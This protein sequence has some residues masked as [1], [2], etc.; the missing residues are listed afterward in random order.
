MK[1]FKK[2]FISFSIFFLLTGCIAGKVTYSPPQISQ[3][4]KNQIVIN[5]NKEALWKQIVPN[6]GKTFFVIN[7]LDKDSG[8]INISY[9]G[10]PEKFIDCGNINSYVKN[11]RGERTYDFQASRSNQDYEIMEK[12]QLYFISRKMNLEGRM[13]IIFEEI[14]ANQTRITVNCRYILTK[15]ITVQDVRGRSSTRTDTISFNSGQK[16]TF[17]AGGLHPGTTCQANGKLEEEV[18]SLLTGR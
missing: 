18:L 12:N 5:R 16:D 8:I 15:T 17:A 1:K 3:S 2:I 4:I 6:L 10:S 14:G 7:N 9:S 11:A 13:N